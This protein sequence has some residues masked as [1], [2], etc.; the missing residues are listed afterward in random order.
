MRSHVR[1]KF[2]SNGR[3]FNDFAGAIAFAFESTTCVELD[4]DPDSQYIV[5]AYWAQTDGDGNM[6]AVDDLI[7][8]QVEGVAAKIVSN[9]ALPDPKGMLK[10]F[11]SKEALSYSAA[12]QIYLRDPAAVDPFEQTRKILESAPAFKSRVQT[13]TTFL[14]FGVLSV[15][16]D[17]TGGI[18]FNPS[19]VAKI[20]TEHR[21]GT[22]LM[23]LSNS[24]L[25]FKPSPLQHLCASHVKSFEYH[26]FYT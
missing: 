11:Q 20:A 25:Y 9:L 16:F 2:V 13:E 19:R 14:V 23:Y 1:E 17:Q 4:S 6:S 18:A 24:P 15:V 21:L 7:K 22:F 26:V 3:N 10:Y 12:C 8:T 5:A